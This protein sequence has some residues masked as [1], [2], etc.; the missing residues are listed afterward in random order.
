VPWSGVYYLQIDPLSERE[1]HPT[2]GAI[3]GVTRFT[4]RTSIGWAALTWTGPTRTCRT[5]LRSDAGGGQA[6]DLPAFLKRQAMPYEGRK[7]RMVLS[8]NIQVRGERGDRALD[9]SFA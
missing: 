1:R 7:D 3:N 8:F 4:D 2:L 5:P 6:G 9:F